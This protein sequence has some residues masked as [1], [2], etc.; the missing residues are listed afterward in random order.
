MEFDNI[1]CDNLLS[2][3]RVM[4][5]VKEYVELENKHWMS[6]REDLSLYLV[7]LGYSSIHDV[8]ISSV[9]IQTRVV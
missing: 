3:Q 2:K 8:F 1:G 7:R 4:N 6:P 9:V 5:V